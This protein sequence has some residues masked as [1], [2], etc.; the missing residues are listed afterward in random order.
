MYY[1]RQNFKSAVHN[2]PYG[3]SFFAPII[4]EYILWDKEM[5]EYENDIRGNT[6]EGTILAQI[7]L[8]DMVDEHFQMGG[9]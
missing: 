3:I 5:A 7:Y 2:R 8:K 6:H 4:E 1:Y 9:I